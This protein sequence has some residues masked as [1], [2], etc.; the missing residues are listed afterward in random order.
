M[1]VVSKK[2][3]KAIIEQFDKKSL[4]G[5]V[6]KFEQIS[7]AFSDAKFTQIINSPAVTTKQKEELVL[8]FFSKPDKKFSNLI[9]LLATNK[10]LHLIPE[11][12]SN[13]KNQMVAMNN[14][15][16]GQIYSN[17]NLSATAIKTLEEVYSKK[18]DA[19]IKFEHIK[20]DIDGIRI[21]VEDLGVEVN[22]S[23]DKLKA[24]LSEYILQAI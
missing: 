16:M 24:K 9:S 6:N 17:A 21:N 19:K 1:S 14:E 8:S 13:L 7:S 22:F 4:E 15:F 12:C 23:L 11:I 18:F 3:T 10:R 20:S 5:V 2:Y